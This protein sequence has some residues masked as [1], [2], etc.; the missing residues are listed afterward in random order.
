M[1]DL[2]VFVETSNTTTKH[3]LVEVQANTFQVLNVKET[4]DVDGG[5]VL[6]VKKSCVDLWNVIFVHRGFTSTCHGLKC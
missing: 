5:F 4:L 6:S 1:D 3:G 2:T